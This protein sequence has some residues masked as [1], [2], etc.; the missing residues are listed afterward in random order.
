MNK[1]IKTIFLHFQQKKFVFILL[2][3]LAIFIKPTKAQIDSLKVEIAT[4]ETLLIDF[5][6]QIEVKHNLTFYYLSEWLD[7]INISDNYNGDYLEN[8]LNKVLKEKSLF[9]TIDNQN[10][11]FI[12][13]NKIKTN[14]FDQSENSRTISDI[15]TNDE[16]KKDVKQLNE[17]KSS[18][19]SQAVG[20]VT[21]GR[22]NG[23]TNKNATI[24]GLITDTDTGE[25]LVGA[26]IYVQ[27]L[28]TGTVTDINGNYFLTLEKGEYEIK[29][30]SVGKEVEERKVKLLSDGRLNMNLKSSLT[31]LDEIIVKED[32]FS[33]TRGIQAGVE[34]LTMKEIKKLPP[35]AGE[36]DVLK[37]S[38]LLPGV[39]TVGES[40]SGYYIRG[41]AADQNL[42][43]INNV[44]IYNTAHMFGFFSTFNSEVIRNFNLYKSNIPVEYG[45]RISS[46]F[47]IQT[48]NGNNKKFSLK[49]GISP[50]TAKLSAEGPI[51]KDKSSY[52]IGLRSTYSDWVL[53]RIENADIRNSDVSFHDLV[54]NFNYKINDNNN[55]RFFTYYSLDNYTLPTKT[56][57]EYSNMAASATW[58]HHFGKNLYSNLSLIYSNYNLNE[59]NNFSELNANSYQHELNHYELN[60]K[61]NYSPTPDHDFT[62][63]YSSKLYKIKPGDYDPIGENSSFK[64]LHL[65]EE[66][67]LET[68][69]YI[70]DKYEI[71]PQLTVQGGIRFSLYNYLGPKTVLS[72]ADGE[73]PSLFSVRDTSNYKSWQSIKN[74]SA[75]DIR[76]SVRYLIN[77]NNSI[78]LGYN[79]ISQYIFLLTNTIAISPTDRWKLCDAH[80]PAISGQQFNIGY[81]K[82]FRNTNI[83]ASAELYYKT[84]KN[85][86]E[87]KNG[88]DPEK[89][90][91]IERDLISGDGRNYGVELMLKKTHGKLNGWINYTYSKSELKF[92]GNSLEETINNGNFYPSNTDKPH[93]LNLTANWKLNRRLS[94]SSNFTYSTGRP[95]TYPVSKSHLG[96]MPVINYSDRNGARIPDYWRLDLSINLEGNLMR[97]KL[98]HS[99]WTFSVYNLTG[100][101]NAYSVYFTTEDGKIK[102]H[103][104]SIFARP[105]FT[106]SYNFKLGNYSS[107]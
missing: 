50:V 18:S 78:K 33:N 102:G 90:E 105:V 47:D 54:T 31:A 22:T 104:I 26:S 88:A 86:K 10:N 2:F 4:P 48:K 43:L 11:I 46:V 99:Y 73:R 21:I 97:K 45:G 100:R 81:Y 63:G 96:K 13:K 55:L 49:G 5:L 106:I 107:E 42:F 58:Q 20:K 70:G 62:F 37:A 19:L 66:S 16:I 67:A 71:N 68:S 6:N 15:Y 34:Q 69:A 95:T 51:V 79:K 87:M 93:N 65:E 91:F 85:L 27:E 35:I 3:L 101:R 75:L 52:I 61:F 77:T 44:P 80:T 76:L 30:Q 56:A 59:E 74:N 24:K 9:F 92:A 89:N 60:H 23:S 12:S 84:A 103:Q 57:Y 14:F 53:N 72:Y 7:S 28:K 25:P 17:R 82:N 39:Q 41:G 36:R 29:F 94:I 32:K 98:A 40:S 83:E 8:V 64:K 1:F 38:L